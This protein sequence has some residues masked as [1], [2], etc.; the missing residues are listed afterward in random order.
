VPLY[1]DGLN[2][3]DW[4]H[5]D[6]HCRALDLVIAQGE[7]GQVYNVGGGNEVRNVDLTH[8]ILELAGRSRDLIKPVADRPGHDR[9]YALSTAKLR[10]LGWQPEVPFETGLAAT[11]AWYRD[12]PGWW[13]PI[14]EQDERYRAYYQAQYGDRRPP[15]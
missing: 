7:N 1:G 12:N 5:V 9:R 8:R 14:K 15:A 13:R 2:I 3:R 6:D 10:G 4:L 11:V